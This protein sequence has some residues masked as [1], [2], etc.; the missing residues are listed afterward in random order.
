MGRILVLDCDKGVEIFCRQLRAMGHEVATAMDAYAGMVAARECPD[1]IVVSLQLPGGDGMKMFERL[2]ANTGT[3]ST[4]IL[5]TF[6]PSDSSAAACNDPLVRF[7]QKG[8]DPDLVGMLVQELLPPVSAPP[9]SVPLE[10]DENNFGGSRPFPEARSGRPLPMDMGA[11][12]DED[13]PPGET[14]EL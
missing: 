13:L 10:S 3:H 2:R 4:P 7:L 12:S 9:A 14:I 8:A 6:D 1:M 5:I 11:P